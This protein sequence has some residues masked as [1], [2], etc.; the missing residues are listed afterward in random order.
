M[1]YH[2]LLYTNSI[3]FEHVSLIFV[4]FIGS[5]VAIANNDMMVFAILY[6][7]VLALNNIT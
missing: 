1:Q 6:P 2:V 3:N 5:T 7:N 4:H